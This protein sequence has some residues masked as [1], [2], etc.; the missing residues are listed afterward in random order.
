ML[1][2]TPTLVFSMLAFSLAP[3]PIATA[4]TDRGVTV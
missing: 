1:A 3:H 2:R 4:Q